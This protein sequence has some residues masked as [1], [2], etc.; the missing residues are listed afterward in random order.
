MLCCPTPGKPEVGA[1]QGLLV[2]LLGVGA[3]AAIALPH[4]ISLHRAAKLVDDTVGLGDRLSSALHFLQRTEEEQGMVPL[5]LLDAAEA[6]KG[7]DLAKVAPGRLFPRL[8]VTGLMLLVV[9]GAASWKL[10]QKGAGQPIDP[11]LAEI[12]IQTQRL[13]KQQVA[14]EALLEL[15]ADGQSEEV[16]QE[17][18]RIRKLIEDLQKSGENMSRKEILARLSREIKELEASKHK[19]NIVVSKAL[20]QLKV[21]KEAIA[22]GD[23]LAEQAAML[24]STHGDLLLRGED[25]TV[26]AEAEKIR[27]AVMTDEERQER[28]AMERE[29]KDLAK[30]GIQEPGEEQEGVD[31]VATVEEEAEDEK[32]ERKVKTTRKVATTYDELMLAAERRDIRE[33]LARAAADETRSIPEY[34]EVY[35]NF[36]R[37]LEELLPTKDMPIGQKEYVRRYFRLIRPKRP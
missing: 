25:G 21:S 4:R 28:E 5:L 20:E 14:L 19:S 1:Y 11:T 22:R 24:E 3:A 6:A 31:W 35:A 18:Q 27:A 13:A 15:S 33:I 2:F 36:K 34:R 32:G 16:Q 30:Q 8:L 37:V 10:Q 9:V 26:V 29:V 23:F 17:L 7:I 12:K